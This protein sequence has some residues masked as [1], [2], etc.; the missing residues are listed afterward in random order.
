MLLVSHNLQM[1]PQSASELQKLPQ[2]SA[3][4]SVVALIKNKMLKDRTNRFFIV[5]PDE[6]GLIYDFA[7]AFEH[8]GELFDFGDVFGVGAVVEIE[9]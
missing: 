9:L 1:V 8:A 2:L 4:E 7:V 3:A 5:F 6:R